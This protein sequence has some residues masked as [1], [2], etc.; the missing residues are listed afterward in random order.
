M[1]NLRRNKVMLVTQVDVLL[2]ETNRG[3]GINR[4]SSHVNSVR[5][6]T[7]KVQQAAFESVRSAG[8]WFRVP[9]IFRLGQ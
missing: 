8:W 4:K 9:D 2:R 1:Q 3:S 7:S 6:A 5:R